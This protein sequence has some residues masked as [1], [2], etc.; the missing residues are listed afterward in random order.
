MPLRG[1]IRIGGRLSGY[2]LHTVRSSLDRRNQ[3][4]GRALLSFLSNNH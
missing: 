1:C 4:S 2:T 3:L